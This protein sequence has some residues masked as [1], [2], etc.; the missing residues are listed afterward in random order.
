MEWKSNRLFKYDIRQNNISR[1]KLLKLSANMM[2]D[3]MKNIL[4]ACKY[5]G[6]KNIFGR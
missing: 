1:A 4:I 2:E 3:A 5:L 6:I